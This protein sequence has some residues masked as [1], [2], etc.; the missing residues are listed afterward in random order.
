M[1]APRMTRWKSSIRFNDVVRNL[2]RLLAP[3]RI[4]LDLTQ[5]DHAERL[6]MDP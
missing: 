2:E 6:G 5:A 4:C 3:V 1:T